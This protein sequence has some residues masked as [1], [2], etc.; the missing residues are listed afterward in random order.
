[1]YKHIAFNINSP[2]SQIPTTC[3]QNCSKQ[4]FPLPV[5]N[6]QN[7][8]CRSAA[9]L[10][11]FRFSIFHLSWL[12]FFRGKNEKHLSQFAISKLISKKLNSI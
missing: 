8:F 6:S 5:P 4:G 2:N 7:S 11:E 3:S 12:Q 10:S 1:M 9:F